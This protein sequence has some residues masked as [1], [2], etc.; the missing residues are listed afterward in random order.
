M[1]LLLFMVW[2]VQMVLLLSQPNEANPGK[3]KLVT[4]PLLELQRRVKDTTWQAPRRKQML[5]GCNNVIRE[6]L[7]QAANN[8]VTVQIRLFPISLHHSAYQDLDLILLL[9]I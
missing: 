8:M 9:T 3:L 2:Q 6:S 4:M 5:Y 1:R 7:I